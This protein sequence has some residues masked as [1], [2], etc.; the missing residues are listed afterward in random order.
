MPK[1]TVKPHHLFCPQGTE[2]IAEPSSN[3]C[4]A[5]LANGVAIEHACDMSKACTT[6]HCIVNQGFNTLAEMDDLEADLLDRAWGLAANSRLSCQVQVG[7]VDLEIEIPRY[8]LNHAS[9]KN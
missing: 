6:C 8:T 1:V 2:F 7:E 3:L 4:A 9:E 5:L